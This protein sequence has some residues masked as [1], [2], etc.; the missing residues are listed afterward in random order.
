[1][2]YLCRI[3]LLRLGLKAGITAGPGTDAGEEVVGGR[4]LVEAGVAVRGGRGGL[5]SEVWVAARVGV[6][7][8]RRT[9]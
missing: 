9:K 6:Y 7:I 1:M 2:F 4:P 3:E 8:W 5:K